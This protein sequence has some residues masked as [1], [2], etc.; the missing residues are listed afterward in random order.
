MPRQK[1]QRCGARNRKP[2]SKISDRAKRYRANTPECLPAGPRRCWR[3][4]STRNLVVDHIDG[5]EANGRRSNLRWLCKKCNATE[6]LRAIDAGR[7]V[8]TEQYNPI[9]LVSASVG[10]DLLNQIDK[11]TAPNPTP[12]GGAHNL[13]EYL[14]A[15]AVLRGEAGEM[16]FS[17]ARA[18]IHNTPAADRS[19][20]AREV[21]RRRRER[22]TDVGQSGGIVPF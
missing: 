7:G 3:C 18:L 14:E 17:E 8:R 11:A 13:P 1:Q 20:F 15:L 6:A 12:S 4:P 16:T 22:G 10:L 21:W 9:D 5:N 2:V 19:S